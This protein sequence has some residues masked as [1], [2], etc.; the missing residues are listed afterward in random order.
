M[1]FEKLS[2]DDLN[3]V[4]GGNGSTSSEVIDL[5][6]QMSNQLSEILANANT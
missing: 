2:D 5:A 1:A 3:R 6:N 4:T